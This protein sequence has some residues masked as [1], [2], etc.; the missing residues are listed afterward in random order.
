MPAIKRDTNICDRCTLKEISAR[1]LTQIYLVAL[2]V[3]A[4]MSLASHLVLD[5][6]VTANEGAASVINVSGRQRMLSQ[7]IA[8]AA[9]Q[10]ALGVPGARHELVT[11]TD[12]FA[13]AHRKL[14]EGDRA[15]HLPAAD[16]PQLKAI[17]FSAPYNLDGQVKVFLAEARAVAEM[18][19]G[20]PGMQGTLASLF[21]SARKPLIDA[22]NAVVSEH[23]RVSE[24]Q[25]VR[26][27]WIQTI[28]FL[29]V[30]VTLV[31][32]ALGIFRPMVH[33][34]MFYTR[35]LLR[36]AATDALTGCFNRR[37]FTDRALAELAR[38]KRYGRSTSMLLIDA[39]HFKRINDTYGHP[40]GDI[41]L[42]RL[43]D[44]IAKTLRPQDLVGRIGGEEFAALLPETGLRAAAKAAER[45]RTGIEEMTILTDEGPVAV[46]VSIGV[47]EFEPDERHF[48]AAMARA[49]IELYAAKAAGRNRVEYA[50]VAELAVPVQAGA[51][52]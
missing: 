12:T 18:P 27:D 4:L 16:T 33:R 47:T 19:D 30:V 45:I 49:D 23:Q 15:L 20:D 43:A 34:V 37:G 42:K 52:A 26:L 39:D 36:I 41:V 40:A 48:E 46:T 6:I 22:L 51:A 38:A 25:L 7:R 14:L 11:A 1:R 3:V 32:E 17:Y 8:G 24:V 2:S 13:A 28:S 5:R 44:G 50:R 10:L 21:S 31:A 29:I 35:E 9:A